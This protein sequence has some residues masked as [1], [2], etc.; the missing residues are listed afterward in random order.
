VGGKSLRVE[1]T[2]GPNYLDYLHQEMRGRMEEVSLQKSL[3]HH[4]GG[5]RAAR[6]RRQ[7][8]ALSESGGHQAIIVDEGRKGVPVSKSAHS[9]D[10]VR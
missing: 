1:E 10:V 7:G 2:V 6:A 3:Q 8:R 9:L 4:V 5:H